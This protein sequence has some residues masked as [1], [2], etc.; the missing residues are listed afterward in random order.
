M[1][2]AIRG[3]LGGCR[4]CFSAMLLLVTGSLVVT[5]CA[6]SESA[7]GGSAIE[8]RT[9]RH[10]ETLDVG[11]ESSECHPRGSDTWTCDVGTSSGTTVVVRVTKTDGPILYETL[12]G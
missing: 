11:V 3:R 1:S 10:I 12:R 4:L 6:R 7:S 2:L 9:A 8:R 5:A